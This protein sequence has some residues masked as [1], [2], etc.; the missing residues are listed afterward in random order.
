MV[1]IVIVM[2]GA[3]AMGDWIGWR[4]GLLRTKVR[5]LYEVLLLL[6]L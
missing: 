3:C 2:K 5:S 6:F 4:E 1:V